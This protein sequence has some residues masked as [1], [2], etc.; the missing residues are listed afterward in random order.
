MNGKMKQIN[1]PKKQLIWPTITMQCNHYGLKK[2][3]IMLIIFLQPSET[4]N[5]LP[6][7]K[8]CTILLFPP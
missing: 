5:Y 3:H 8:Q 2:I 4:L 6:A 1:L 7:N